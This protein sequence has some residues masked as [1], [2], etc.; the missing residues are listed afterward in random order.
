VFGRMRHGFMRLTLQWKIALSILSAFVMV[1]PSV[2]LSLF[3][4]TNL[5]DGLTVITE[6]D[7]KLGRTATDL[8]LVM[9]DIG[10]HERNFRMFGG[11]TE[12]ESVEKLIARADSIIRD[13]RATASPG[14]RDILTELS[15]HLDMYSNSFMMLVE[16]IAAHPPETSDAQKARLSK[17]LGAFQSIYRKILADLEKASPAERDS[18][19][20]KAEHDLDIFSLDLLAMSGDQEQPSYIKENL[21]TSRKLFLTKADELSRRSWENMRLHREETRQVEARAKRNI[22]SVLILTGLVSIFMIL[23]LPKYIIHPISSLNRVFRKAEEGDLKAF[24]HIHSHDEIGDLAMSYNRM[25]ERL[26]AFDDLKTRKIASQK[27]AFDR[28]VENLDMPVCILSIEFVALFYNA[29]F[30][31]LF[32]KSVPLKPPDNGWDA[33]KSE[34]MTSLVEA[35]KARVAENINNFLIEFEDI[36]GNPV[37]MKGRVV[38]NSLME[39][40]SI[41]LIGFHT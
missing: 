40:E 18:I 23:Y 30:A 8:S 33:K 22:I 5:L 1:L 13:T 31:S 24:A 35:L 17:R 11:R 2:S 28:F 14:E 10:R 3:Y 41:V 19:L 39:P 37:R 12:R 38:R 15:G 20:V 32:G 34:S 27:R 36:D 26:A 7:V 4:F 25:L 9:H 6:R 29:A 16:H 21:E